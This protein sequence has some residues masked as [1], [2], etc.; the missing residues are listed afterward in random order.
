MTKASFSVKLSEPLHVTAQEKNWLDV[1][2]STTLALY[3]I[4]SSRY[5]V[6]EV[7]L[8]FVRSALS[9]QQGLNHMC[10]APARNHWP[11]AKDQEQN[12]LLLE[13]ILLMIQLQAD[14]SELTLPIKYTVP[15]RQSSTS[16]NRDLKL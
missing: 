7:L 16:N 12:L 11:I 2:T 15:P 3:K 4:P 14:V 9:C 6:D 5:L 13:I 8:W 1:S 10:P